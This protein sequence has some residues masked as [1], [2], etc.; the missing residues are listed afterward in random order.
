S[1]EQLWQQCNRGAGCLTNSAATNLDWAESPSATDAAPGHNESMF[2]QMFERS[3]DA[4]FLSDPRR[5][6]FVDC[7]QAAVEMMRASAKEQLLMMNPAA[8]SPEFQPDGRSSRERVHED[9]ILALSRGSHRFEWRAR[10]MDGTE[11]SVEVLLTPVQTRENMFVAAVCRDITERKRAEHQLL[12]LTQTLER[13][14]DERTAELSASEA[15]FRALVEHAP[16][17]IVVYSVD[18]GR[19]LFGNQH[20]CD[21]YGVPM[22]ELPKLSPADVSPEFQPGGRRTSDLVREK[23]RGVMEGGISVF[24]WVHKRPGDRL[25]NTE[26]RL[27]RLPAEGRTLIRASIIDDTERKV[28]ERAL[29]ESEAKYRALF[30]GASQGVVLHDKHQILEVNPAA[31]RILGRRFAHEILGKHPSEFSPP[32]QPNGESSD[33]LARQYIDECLTRGS[34]RFDWLACDPTGREIPLEVSLTRIEWSGRQVIQAFITDITER[35][36]AQAALAE[37]EARFSAAFHASPA[38]LGIFNGSDGRIDL[39]NDAYLNWLGYPR[40]EV[41]GRTCLELGL[42]ENTDERDSVLKDLQTI[43][44]IRQRECR[45]RNR[46]GECSTILLSIEPIKVN[47]TPRMLSMVVD[48]TQRKRAEEDLRASEARLRESEARFSAAFHASPVITA[49]ARASDGTFVLANDAFLNWAGYERDEVLGRTA[50]ELGIWENAEERNRFWDEVRSA[51]SVRARECRLRNRCG[52][53]STMLASGAVIALNGEDHFLGILLDITQRKQIEAELHRTLSREKELSQLKSN[54][55]SMVSHEFRTPLGIIQSS[56]E[57]LRDFHGRMQPAERDEQLESISR[58]ARRMAGMMEEVLV[59][60]RLDAGKLDFQPAVLDLNIFCRRVVDEVLSATNR[61]CLIELSTS[62]VPSKAKADERLL[63]HIFTNLLS[64]AVK[65]SE[66]GASV[67]FIVQRNG[68]DAVCVIRDKGIGISE[69]DQQHLFKAFHR[70]S[71]VGTLPGTGLGLLLVKRCADLHGGKVQV[72]SR[73]GE[74]TTVTVTLPVFGT[75]Q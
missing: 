25:I 34:A 43:G 61:R 4:M 29:R 50:I 15:R 71:N 44:S 49:I 32:V 70:G 65:Y 45:W 17:A 33:A 66:A 18:T 58:N 16:E 21:L 53:Y 5:E 2:R 36:R 48:I 9:T 67:H 38:F 68:S 37:S 41:I 74:G 72:H 19:F 52:R 8:L 59:L 22:S 27:L 73:I 64:N 24:E 47:G 7:N 42:W 54:F 31:V 26:V 75:N 30:E 1:Y 11:F 10:R 62:S 55:V 60:S 23:V 69:E 39:A 57:L 6:I 12:D 28:A 13:R 20:A 56:A 63:A 40:E 3:A 35:K 51:G 46:R 14:V